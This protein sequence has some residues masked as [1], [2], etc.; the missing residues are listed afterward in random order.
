MVVKNMKYIKKS[1][2]LVTAMTFLFMLAS[3]ALA[4]TYKK[5]D[6]PS[7]PSSFV[8]E[9]V[10]Y[11]LNGG[12]SSGDISRVLGI[13]DGSYV[14]L[15]A[16]GY[17]ILKF[18][19]NALTCSGDDQMDL[20]VF[21]AGSSSQELVEVFISTDGEN[22]IRIG[23][24]NRKTQ[25]DIDSVSGVIYGEKYSYIKLVD[26]NGLNSGASYEGAD[27]DA[28]GAITSTS[29]ATNEENNNELPASQTEV[30]E[31]PTIALPMIA[32]MGLALIYGKK[33]Q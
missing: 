4:E 2:L 14:S 23:T 10:E 6:F 30:P 19:D 26:Y 15:G 11:Q 22:W 7:G 12:A 27:M 8:D 29:P 28:V 24:A 25:F 31:F 1:L 20:A 21:E 16:H 18:T 17:A 33:K 3:P 9:V 32:I 5:V 13:A